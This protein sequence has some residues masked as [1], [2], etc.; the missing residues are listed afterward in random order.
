MTNS[1]EDPISRSLAVLVKYCDKNNIPYVVVGGVAVLIF[2]RTRMT[3]DIDII[4]DHN[5]LDRLDFISFL[6]SNGFDANM[7]D[8]AAFDEGIHASIFLKEGMFRID[9]KGTYSENE[10]E[11]IDMAVPEEF[12]GV[13]LM[14]DHPQNKSLCL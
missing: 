8:L 4:I 1:M 12:N 7:S 3:L 14:V 11:S 13:K 9:L 6:K 5:A 2:G 10:R